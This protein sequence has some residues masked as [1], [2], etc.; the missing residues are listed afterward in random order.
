M[1]DVKNELAANQTVLMV[2]PSVEYNDILVDSMKQFGDSS[3]CYITTN[4]T[5]DSLKE[6]FTKNKI[7]LDNVV[8]IDAISKT[9]KK[10]EDSEE[11][12]YYVSSP[13]ALT[14]LSLVVNK[15]LKHNF[16][17]VIFDSL[18]N[19]LIYQK[20]AQLAKFIASLVNKIKTMETKALFYSLDINEQAELIKQTGMFVD[21]VIKTTK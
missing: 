6:T 8:F 17:Y 15:F 19:L 7:K 21:K 4:K 3:V 12:V 9:M 18:S 11:S 16:D 14:E 5:Y 13:G 2:M 10:V 1:I 20:K